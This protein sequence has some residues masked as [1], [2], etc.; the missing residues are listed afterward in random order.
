[1]NMKLSAGHSLLGGCV[2]LSSMV[3]GS[4]VSADVID[5]QITLDG[6]QE[7]P[8][9]ETT[10]SGTGTATLDT[11]TLEFS[12]NITFGDLEGN[13][14]AAH[15]HGP[16]PQCTN[17]G[18]VIGLTPVSPMNGAQVVSSDQVDQI[19]AGHWYVN[20]HTDLHG[21]GEIR[22]QVEPTGIADPVPGGVAVGDRAR[23]TLIT[24][25]MTAPNWAASAPGIAGRLYVGDQDGILWNVDL[26]TGAKSVFLDVSGQVVPLGIFG[27]DTFDERGLLGFAFAP[28]YDESG[29]L[30]TYTSEPFD[31][32]VPGDFSTM[33]DGVD[34]NHQAVIS[35]WQVNNPGD[36][37]AAVDMGSL[38]VLMR[39]DQPQFNH[40]GGAVTF[41]PDGMLYVALGDGGNADDQD[42]GT[43]PFG[44]PVTG[45]GCIGNSQDLETILGTVIRI[46]P[47]GNNSGNGNYGI[48]GSNPFV[49][50]NTVD[51]I[52]AFGLRN[53]FRMSFDM[54]SGDLI[55]ADVGQNHLEEIDV[56]ESGDNLGWNLMEGSFRFVRNGASSGYAAN[57]DGFDT[58][59]LVG[60]I[61]EY[62]HDEGIAIIGGFVYRGA[63]LPT[64]D[65]RYIFGEFAPTFQSDGRLF[66]L[67]GDDTMMEFD[68]AGGAVNRSV[69]G[70]GQDAAG[71]V[72]VLGNSTGVPFG[73]TGEVYRIDPPL[74]LSA[75]GDCPGK[76]MFTAEGVTPGAKV[77]FL[78][79]KGLGEHD[80]PGNLLC[81]G[82]MLNLDSSV[83]VGRVVTADGNGVASAAGF[84]GNSQCGVFYIQ[85][86]ELADSSNCAVSNVVHVD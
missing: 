7:V 80:V 4:S 81:G 26:A 58:S 86:V 1:M 69:L 14:T 31:A 62:D 56:V 28:D 57:T 2:L 34:P 70:F 48:P 85:A 38:R 27:Q 37:N 61:A 82:T 78:R 76:V 79:A 54:D 65:G 73:D 17:G 52:Y 49:G 83:A 20:V 29:L 59:G 36:A 43:D 71:E 68:L 19:L 74:L 47:L 18:V 33:P 39:I 23:L 5:L 30:Y 44:V 32:Q 53:P 46:D 67:D 25:G 64:F 13:P 84:F 55:V 45:H 75:D 11:D 41:G 8:A 77:A 66:Y 22:G 35:E 60:P 9:V 50:G 24:D 15:F 3:C 10:G 6:S 72:Y 16:A 63:A 40:D 12:W 21:G 42:T 51:E